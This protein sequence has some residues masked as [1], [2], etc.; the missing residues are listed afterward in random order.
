MKPIDTI[1]DRIKPYPA[2]DAIDLTDHERDNIYKGAGGHVAAFDGT[3][4]V[5]LHD[6]LDYEFISGEDF[7]DEV[8]RGTKQAHAVAKQWQEE[9]LDVWFV[10]CS[11]GQLCDPIEWNDPLTLAKVARHLGE[12]AAQ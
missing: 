10:V 3:R 7:G 4:L 8:N 2:C 11:C 6:V 5:R 12:A 9:G 1:H